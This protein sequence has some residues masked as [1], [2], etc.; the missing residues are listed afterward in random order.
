MRYMPAV[1]ATQGRSIAA[2]FAPWHGG[3][4]SPLPAR[5]GQKPSS[6]A[7]S[8]GHHIHSLG[9]MGTRPRVQGGVAGGIGGVGIRPVWQTGTGA[10]VGPCA[11][12]ASQSSAGPRAA[13]KAR[14]RCSLA[15]SGCHWPCVGPGPNRPSAHRPP[16]PRPRLWLHRQHQVATGLQCSHGGMGIVHQHTV[17]AARAFH[18]RS[19]LKMAPN[20]V[21]AAAQNLLQPA[22]RKARQARTH[23]RVDDVRGHHAGEAVRQTR[24]GRSIF[25]NSACRL[26]SS[27]GTSV[28]GIGAHI[29]MAGEV[30]LLQCSHARLGSKPSARLRPGW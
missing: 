15:G 2:R 4:W 22:R 30:Q 7:R 6:Q 16:C 11:C 17:I 8:P 25:G 27:T 28:C 19:S 13:A 12:K 1:S 3:W 20:L 26:R 24:H 29:A 10:L 5:Q 18:A 9:K 23:L 21:P 14:R